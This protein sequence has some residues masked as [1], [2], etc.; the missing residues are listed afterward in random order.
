ME[1]R[2]P[3]S[4]G[5]T[6]PRQLLPMVQ[7]LAEQVVA[8]AVGAVEA[9]GQRISCKKGCGSCCRQLVPISPVEARR[10]SDLVDEMPE[11]RRAAV[12]ARFAEAR[13]RF[14]EAGLVDKLLHPE[15]W[16][17]DE[18]RS[19]GVRYFQVGVPCPLLEEESCSIHPDRPITCREYLVTSPAEHCARPTAET[20]R[21]VPMPLKVW[22]ALA[23]LEKPASGPVP[24]V[25]L[26][27]APEWAAARPEELAP[28]PGPELVRDFFQHLTGKTL[29]PPR[30]PET[31]FGATPSNKEG[32]HERAV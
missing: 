2:I 21:P 15:T 3:V 24:W 17:G 26:V 11:P 10:I 16:T 14:E 22:T 23:A 7:A 30:V 12:R 13:R 29:P 5:P 31:P 6:R 19:L 28:R 4:T 20:V 8:G 1:I 25:P 32:P 9:E 27:L 18:I